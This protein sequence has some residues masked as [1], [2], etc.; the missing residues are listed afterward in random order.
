MLRKDAWGRPEVE[1]D[2]Q[3]VLMALERYLC[4]GAPA[5]PPGV[6]EETVTKPRSIGF[7]DPTAWIE[8]LFSSGGGNQVSRL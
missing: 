4:S 2:H 3:G 1:A 8:K 5:I 7:D 6:C